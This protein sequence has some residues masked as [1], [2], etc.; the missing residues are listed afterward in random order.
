MRAS[1]KK[2]VA[3][4]PAA[5]E[6]LETKVTSWIVPPCRFHFFAILVFTVLEGTREVIRH[7]LRR[8]KALVSK[9]YVASTNERNG[10]GSFVTERTHPFR[11]SSSDVHQS[12]FRCNGD[13]QLKDRSVPAEAETAASSVTES[14]ASQPMHG[15]D[16]FLASEHSG[17]RR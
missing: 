17:H 3:Q 7:V 4:E 15:T 2:G 9:A 8:G 12:V 11:S 6:K 5:K 10:C 1:N 13:V 16:V 14:S